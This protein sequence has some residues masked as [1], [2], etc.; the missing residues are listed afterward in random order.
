MNKKVIMR[1]YSKEE[2]IY[3][4][5]RFSLTIKPVLR[6]IHIA[7]IHFSVSGIDPIEHYKILS[8][9]FLDKIESTT[10][11][12]LAIDGDIF[13]H[14]CMGNNI[15]L[16]YAI[17]FFDRCLNRCR[18]INATMIVIDGTESHDDHQIINLFGHYLSDRTV[19]LRIVTKVKFE[20]IKGAKVLCI[21]ELYGM[22][23]EYYEKFLFNSGRY[24][25]CFMHGMFKGAVYQEGMNDLDSKKA[26]T[27]TIDDFR[28][29]L[30]PII[31]GHVHIPG[32]YK[33]YFYYTGSPIRFRH[34]EEQD[35]G[36]LVVLYDMNNC[37]HYTHFEKIESFRFDTI[38]FDEI[39]KKDLNSINQYIQQ[40]KS[41]G[42]YNLRIKFSRVLN[43]DELDI[44]TILK[45][46][47]RRDKYIKIEYDGNK[48]KEQEKIKQEIEDKYQTY[49]F[50][51]DKGLT[52]KQT[53]VQY[54]N[55]EE[56]CEFITV[57]EFEKIL[58]GDD[59]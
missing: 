4:L 36:F 18:Q 14:R 45:N 34:G 22:G 2:Q 28:N 8:D 10:F 32:C 13:D 35:K 33:R 15:A 25:L 55:H 58:N 50:L 46:Y 12:I 59:F 49:S 3:N 6:M 16:Q 9:Q 17:L 30:G 27:F 54:V 43:N 31:S 38:Y 44:L 41:N 23:K 19:D 40:L 47:Y 48:A 26:P 11:D 53:F 39:I 42:I 52:P 1:R 5:N 37:S 56:K 24:D 29:C 51:F 7:D 21:P 57:D 20:Y